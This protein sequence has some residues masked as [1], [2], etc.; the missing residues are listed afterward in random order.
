[1]YRISLGTVN[2]GRKSNDEILKGGCKNRMLIKHTRIQFNSL[3]NLVPG[4][5]MKM[6]TEPLLEINASEM[7]SFSSFANSSK[8]L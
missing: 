7:L 8:W 5:L 1:M 2:Q 4:Q 6:L 3:A